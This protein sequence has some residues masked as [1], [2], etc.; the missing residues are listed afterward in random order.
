MGSIPSASSEGQEFDDVR[1]EDSASQVGGQYLGTMSAVGGTV[2]K[3]LPAPPP[4]PPMSG[5]PK[6]PRSRPGKPPM[7]PPKLPAKFSQD[8]PQPETI[9]SASQDASQEA[10]C[11]ESPPPKK[12]KASEPTEIKVLWEESSHE[13]LLQREQWKK[14]LA[15]ML[16]PE[17][18]HPREP[19]WPRPHQLLLRKL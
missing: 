3:T 16:Q 18:Q 9:A 5:S 15:M 1:P 17:V 19:K 11:Q 13:H 2:R 7:Q 10:A 4:P 8:P 12:A 6:Q 14:W